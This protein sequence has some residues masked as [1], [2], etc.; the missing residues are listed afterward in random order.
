MNDIEIREMSEL[1]RKTRKAVYEEATRPFSDHSDKHLRNKEQL[2]SSVEKVCSEADLNR[3]YGADKDTATS[4][5]HHL[6]TKNRYAGIR[7]KIATTEIEDIQNIFDEYDRFSLK[8]WDI[9]VNGQEI[10][11]GD[12][13]NDFLNRKGNFENKQTI[14]N[15]PKLVK[16]VNVA[17]KLIEYMNNKTAD[18]PVLDFIRN[19]YG[20]EE[21]WAIHEHLMNLGYRSDLTA[22]H[23]MMDI[24]FPVIKPDIVISKIFLDWGWLHKII[25]DLPCDLSFK[26]L[27]CKGSKKNPFKGKYG[28]D[29]IYTSKKIYKPIIELS[30]EIVLKTDQDDLKDDIGWVS[31][32][33]I[34]EFDIFLVKYG[35]KIEPE[36]GI[37]RTLYDLGIPNKEDLKSCV[38]KISR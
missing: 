35:Q 10:R 21:I 7:A 33:P 8:S 17:R 4:I 20:D 38:V 31:T 24:G 30:R 37:E 9:V 19:G 28:R 5:W 6:W 23:F 34:R 15:I 25:K 16:I 22:L 27:Q 3:Y 14:G 26:D 29:F 32:N 1:Y 36:F 2:R 12:Q 11:G 13:V 18:T